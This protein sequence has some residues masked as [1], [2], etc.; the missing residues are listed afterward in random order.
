LNEKKIKKT[1]GHRKRKLTPKTR[2]IYDQLKPCQL[3]QN[4]CLTKKNKETHCPRNL[5]NAH[6]LY[7][8]SKCHSV[9]PYQNKKPIPL[10]LHCS[11]FS[12]LLLSNPSLYLSQQQGIQRE[13]R[14]EQRVC[15]FEFDP[16]QLG[17]WGSWWRSLTKGSGLPQ[18]FTLIALKQAASTTTLHPIPTT[19]PTTPMAEPTATAV[20][21]R[22]PPLLGILTSF[23]VLFDK[24][25]I[26]IS[27]LFV[28]S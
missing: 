23:F 9:F 13:K 5:R 24:I 4:K 19:T 16:E 12:C 3:K 25:K 20:S 1:T 15:G 8:Y 11:H 26:F 14:K 22:M 7:K 27:L 18:G 2:L 28:C 21:K 10:S 17:S 6:Q